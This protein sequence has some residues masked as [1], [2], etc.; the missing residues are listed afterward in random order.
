[1]TSKTSKYMVHKIPNVSHQTS[2]AEERHE[3]TEVY[4]RMWAVK[5]HVSVNMDKKRD[6]L[7]PS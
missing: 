5:N 4:S 7:G 6:N 1:M 2:G 3:V